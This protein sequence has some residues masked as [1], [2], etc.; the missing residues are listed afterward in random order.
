MADST[1]SSATPAANSNDLN[2]PF[3]FGGQNFKRW[4]SKVLFYLK[5]MK[6]VWILTAKNPKKVDTKNMS[7]EELVKHE[8]YAAKWENDEEDCRN[9][10]LNCLSDELY[11]YYSHTYNSAKRM[12]KALQQKYD[13]EEAK[14]KKY[15]Q[16]LFQLKMSENVSVVAQTYDLQMIVH[17]IIS[18]GI[19]INEKMQVTAIID[20]LLNSWK[21]FQ[22]GLRHKQLELSIVNL[23]ARLQIEAEVRRQDKKNEAFANNTH[24]NHAN[25]HQG[26]GNGAKV[27]FL[28]SSDSAPKGQNNFQ[29]QNNFLNTRGSI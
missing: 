29:R 24:S 2:K 22:K 20:K 13:T 8:K 10:F 12:W 14:K 9:Y 16:P 28:T 21:E 11:D 6:V 17:E 5:L 23:M 18:E 27:N 15:A 25:N 19:K 3:R 26:N 1:M 7:E 4:A